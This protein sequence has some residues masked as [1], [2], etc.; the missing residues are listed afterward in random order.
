VESWLGLTS[1]IDQHTCPCE[2][3]RIWDLPVLDRFEEIEECSSEEGAESGSEP[4]IVS[5]FQA[6]GKAETYNKSN[7]SW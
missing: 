1:L 3:Y 4:C 7:G 6:K 5:D 2:V